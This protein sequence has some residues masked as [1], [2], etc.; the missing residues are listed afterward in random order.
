MQ[1]G[2]RRGTEE[3]KMAEPLGTIIAGS[4]VLLA[5]LAYAVRAVWTVARNIGN[6]K[7]KKPC[8]EHS[9]KI[10]QLETEAKNFREW[11]IDF[12]KRNENDHTWI[13]DAINNRK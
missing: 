3:G 9:V 1:T 5:G 13:F 7:D 8:E 11:L 6:N 2:I 4:G 10:G 12:D